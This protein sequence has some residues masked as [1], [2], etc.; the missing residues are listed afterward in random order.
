MKK[1]NM[2]LIFN[3]TDD[4]SRLYTVDSLGTHRYYDI[5]FDSHKTALLLYRLYDANTS[6]LLHMESVKSTP[7]AVIKKVLEKVYIDTL[8]D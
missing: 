6:V 2:Q 8:Q 3:I 7:S 5:N 1:F 4:E